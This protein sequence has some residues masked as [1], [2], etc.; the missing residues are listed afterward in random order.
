MLPLLHQTPTPRG[1]SGRFPRPNSSSRSTRSPGRDRRN[2]QS[3]VAQTHGTNQPPPLP[4]SASW[5]GHSTWPLGSSCFSYGMRTV[6]G[7]PG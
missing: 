6:T 1:R 5:A 4:S 7:P 3:L 2:K